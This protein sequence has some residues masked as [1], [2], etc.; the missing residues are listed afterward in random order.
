M[1]AIQLAPQYHNLKDINDVEPFTSENDQALFDELKAVLSKHG[2]LSR[3]GITLLHQHFD[4]VDGE[5]LV[6]LCDVENRLLTIKPLPVDETSNYKF[7]ETSW[8]FD[9]IGAGTK[10]ILRC[11]TD[12]GRHKDTEHIE[13]PKK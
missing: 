9:I 2:A 3:F 8:R 6:E 4:L 13:V 7:I 11:V 10:C 5:M 12:A 1:K